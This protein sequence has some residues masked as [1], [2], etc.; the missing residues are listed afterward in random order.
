MKLFLAGTKG[1]SFIT[2]KIIGDNMKVFLTGGNYKNAVV[3][4][5]MEDTM[6]I[7]IAGEHPV[8]NGPLADWSVEKLNILE[9]YYYARNNKHIQRLISAMPRDR[10]MVDSGA[11]TFHKGVIKTDWDKY[12]EEY[13]EFVVKHDV[14]IYVEMDIDIVVGLDKVEKLR[15]KLESITKKKCLPVWHVNR[16]KQYFFDMC[17]EYDYVGIGGLT[18]K[19]VRHKTAKYFPWFIAEAHRRGAKIHGF[20]F[21]GTDIVNYGFDSVDSTSW[22]YGNRGGFLYHFDG[23]GLKKIPKPAG[24]RMKSKEVAFH[25]FNE[26]VK[27][28]HYMETVH[29]YSYLNKE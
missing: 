7:F 28:G 11:H 17:D 16:G 23:R 3:D 15:D 2:E 12:T 5:I 24:T 26:W 27:F 9:S 14:D 22:L 8:K 18:D 10:L 20:A 6:R 29:N 19:T 4:K 13:A 25:N 21:T 1:R